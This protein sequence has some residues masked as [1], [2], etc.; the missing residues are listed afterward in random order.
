VKAYDGTIDC[1]GL[2]DECVTIDN[3]TTEDMDDGIYIKRIDSTYVLSVFITDVTSIVSYGSELFLDA[4]QKVSTIYTPEKEYPIF[5][6]K[7][8]HNV[9]SLVPGEA[10]KTICVDIVYDDKYE[11]I[12]TSL[13]YCVA[14]S[15]RKYSYEEFEIAKD[16]KSYW[17]RKQLTAIS[18]TADSHKQIEFC[19]LEYNKYIGGL[20]METIYRVQG[21]DLAA[22]YILG[23]GGW[24]DGLG[25]TNYLHATSPIR[26]ITDLY[27]QYCL[28]GLVVGVTVDVGLVNEMSLLIKRFHNKSNLLDLIYRYKDDPIIV[29]VSYIE[30]LDDKIKVE[31]SLEPKP[32]R[33][34]LPASDVPELSEDSNPITYRLWGVHQGGIG[35]LRL[36]QIK[37]S[38]V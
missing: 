29:S 2:I 36:Q 34:I 26:R 7:L 22:E 25:C 32:Q 10:R 15:R 27:V 3:T 24:H 19:M 20:A 13:R 4:L 35:R 6:S 21:K 37:K 11:K 1:G 18:G 12:S 16:S 5:P 33:Y 14:R 17:L 38:D 23:S 28:K 8:S 9:M 31:I 30:R